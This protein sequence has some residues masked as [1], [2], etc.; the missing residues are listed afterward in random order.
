MFQRSFGPGGTVCR[1]EVDRRCTIEIYLEIGVLVAPPAKRGAPL[2]LQVHGYAKR[3]KFYASAL[4]ISHAIC[5][6]EM[7]IAWERPLFAHTQSSALPVLRR[8][9]MLQLF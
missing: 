2:V 8:D 7:A 4:R 9:P 3:G 6:Q 5:C 1:R